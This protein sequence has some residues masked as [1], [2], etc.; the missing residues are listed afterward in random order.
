MSFSRFSKFPSQ[1]RALTVTARVMSSWPPSWQLRIHFYLT[2]LPV[3]VN[4]VIGLCL[5]FMPESTVCNIICLLLKFFDQL[6][7]PI[8]RKPDLQSGES[9]YFLLRA[10]KTQ[11]WLSLPLVGNGRLFPQTL[12]SKP[13]EP[14][15]R[16]A[17]S[18]QVPTFT[19][20]LSTQA[21]PMST[22]AVLPQ[23]CSI[24]VET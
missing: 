21:N 2:H 15:G 5:F 13:L 7:S 8:T 20:P 6:Q 3:C 4:P 10:V 17:A 22:W 24:F 9:N 1:P 19:M 16:A 12:F 23:G 18:W 11:P 14:S